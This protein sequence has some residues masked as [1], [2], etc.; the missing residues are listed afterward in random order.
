MAL[1]SGIR[2]GIVF[3]VFLGVLSLVMAV[4]ALA[5][6]E[7][8]RTANRS[9]MGR[10]ITPDWIFEKPDHYEFTPLVSN[11]D[12]QNQHPGAWEGQDWDPSKWGPDWTPD[13]A[14]QKFFRARI[15]EKQYMAAGQM[16]VVELG[17]TFYKLSDLDQRRT[18]KLLTDRYEIFKSGHKVVEL[19]DWSTHD[20][21]GTY[22]PKG[23]FLN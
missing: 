15:F 23:L 14:I 22:T 10:V 3:S 21:V 9:V 19:E 13:I 20:I 16:P 8:N 2:L 11:Q 7:P 6:D 18:L 4:P 5:Y 12:P 1:M 17:P